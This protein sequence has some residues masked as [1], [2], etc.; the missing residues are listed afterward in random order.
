MVSDGWT[1]FTRKTQHIIE[2]ELSMRCIQSS[3]N[4]LLQSPR[5]ARRIL[6]YVTT[7]GYS[8]AAGFD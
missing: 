7:A 1:D 2:T 6:S 8:K 4:L 5:F 3:R